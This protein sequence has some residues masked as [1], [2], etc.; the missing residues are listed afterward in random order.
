MGWCG[1]H[2]KSLQRSTVVSG[3]NR[4]HS[5]APRAC[6]RRGPPASL[7]FRARAGAFEAAVGT[8]TW[9]SST[10]TEPQRHHGRVTWEPREASKTQK[11]RR[12]R[13]K[14]SYFTPVLEKSHPSP[15]P[16]CISLIDLPKL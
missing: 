12:A 15:Y 11:L 7:A 10:R 13:Q 6:L 3:G 16:I 4:S 9:A 14:M 2:I 5:A 8:I 1:Q